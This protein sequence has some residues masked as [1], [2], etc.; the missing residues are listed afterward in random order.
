MLKSLNG[1]ISDKHLKDVEMF[2]DSHNRIFGM[3]KRR[4]FKI[5]P[6]YNYYTISKSGLG[7]DFIIVDSIY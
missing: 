4:T 6:H 2:C 7:I 3:V 5:I 1:M